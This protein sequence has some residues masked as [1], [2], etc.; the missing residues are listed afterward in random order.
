MLD[1]SEVV[2]MIQYTSNG[3]FRA[4]AKVLA[5]YKGDLK[6]GDEIWISGFS[7]RYGPIDKVRYGDKYFGLPE[8]KPIRR[9]AVRRF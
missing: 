4:S 2:A 5:V 6:T 7:N 3:S 9:A 8:Q 1:S